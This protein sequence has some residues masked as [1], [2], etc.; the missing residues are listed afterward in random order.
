MYIEMSLH[1]KALEN[2]SARELSFGWN[3][4]YM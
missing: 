2:N 1:T 4:F 3:Y